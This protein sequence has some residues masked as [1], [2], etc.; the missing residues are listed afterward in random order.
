MHNDIPGPNPSICP[1]MA[2]G[3]G[4][5]TEKIYATFFKQIMFHR[6]VDS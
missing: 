5:Q 6:W 2:P 3:P 4:I 1:R